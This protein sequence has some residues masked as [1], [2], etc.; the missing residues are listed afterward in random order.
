MYYEVEKQYE[1]YFTYEVLDGQV[2]SVLLY[3]MEHEY[4]IVCKGKLT[5]RFYRQLTEYMIPAISKNIK[6]YHPI[7]ISCEGFYN[8]NFG[9][10]E[11]GTGLSCGVD[12]FYTIY[13]NL[14]TH[15]KESGLN[16]T[17]LCYFNV[18]AAGFGEHAT[19]IYETRKKIFKNVAD[20]LGCKFLTVDSNMT[21]FLNQDHE[22]T[23]TFRT[24]SVPLVLQKMFKLYYFSSG[25]NYKSFKIYLND[26][27]YYDILTLPNLSTDSTRFELVGG[28]TTR[29]GKVNF[30]CDNQVVK[31]NLSVCF[32]ETFNCNKCMKCKRT[33]LNLYVAGK[34]DEYG[35][36]FDL[37]YFNKNKHKIIRW[38]IIYKHMVDLEEIVISLKNQKKLTLFERF[39]NFLVR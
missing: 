13:K 3:A 34:L 35:K 16:L 39:L 32:W 8:G 30:I 17:Y 31:D 10:K 18:G 5:E 24:I 29:Q 2:S 23:Y 27:G 28:E 12:S 6:E 19:E 36:C 4:N 7:T 22:R 33:M 1:K 37:E 21:D 26:P 9:G 11:T 38:A 25:V 14:N 20:E 15:S